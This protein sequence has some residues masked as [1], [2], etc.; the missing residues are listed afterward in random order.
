MDKLFYFS[1]ISFNS[2]GDLS[3]QTSPLELVWWTE[4]YRESVGEKSPR[5]SI[6][7]TTVVDHN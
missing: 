2:T 7:I 5:Y 6:D 3:F 1:L 4:K